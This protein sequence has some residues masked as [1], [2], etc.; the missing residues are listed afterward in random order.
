VRP[1]NKLFPFWEKTCRLICI[2]HFKFFCLAGNNC[3]RICTAV[4][5]WKKS[6][7]IFKTWYFHFEKKRTC[8]SAFVTLNFFVFVGNNCQR[9]C[10]TVSLW[11]KSDQKATYFNFEK[12]LLL[13]FSGRRF[14]FVKSETRKQIISVLRKNVPA[15]LHFKLFCLCQRFCTEVSL[16]K[17]SDQKTT[18]FRFKKMLLL[19]FSGWRFHF[20]KSRT[21][22]QLIFVLKK[23]YYWGSAVDGFTL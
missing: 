15:Y 16:C 23:C 17:K 10:T 19:R 14:H 12:M 2:R 11:K 21:R 5:L 6:D 3:Q 1:E 13:R 7:Q 8:L 18:Y 22:K 4:S 9:F 20:V